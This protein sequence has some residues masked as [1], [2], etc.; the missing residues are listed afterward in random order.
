MT[1]FKESVMDEEIINLGGGIFDEGSLNDLTG[2]EYTTESPCISY[3]GAENLNVT[4]C[5][6]AFTTALPDSSIN[7][8]TCK[9]YQS[10]STVYDISDN[11]KIIA[12][13]KVNYT[14]SLS[15]LFANVTFSGQDDWIVE[16][17]GNLD[18]DCSASNAGP[19]QCSFNGPE[20]DGKMIIRMES[21]SDDIG[22]PSF[23]IGRIIFRNNQTLMENGIPFT[24]RNDCLYFSQS[25]NSTNYVAT[26][27]FCCIDFS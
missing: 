14:Y 23:L 1:V 20:G 10:R 22:L 17:S 11:Y 19:G 13:A 15:I 12:T 3:T 9:N 24:K 16:L 25:L 8:P 6:T 4:S 27:S 7:A 2:R 18:D 21:F 5:C 26:S